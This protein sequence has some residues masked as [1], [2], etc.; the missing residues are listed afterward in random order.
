MK[1]WLIALALAFVVALTA[2]AVGCGGGGE[3]G[4][5]VPTD[6]PTLETTLR[7]IAP[8]LDDLPSGFAIQEPGEVY[9][10]N[11]EA[12]ATDPD[13]KQVALDRYNEWGRLLGYR[14]SYM[15]NDTMGAFINGG[16]ATVTV[17]L[18]IFRTSEGAIAAMEWGR[19]VA[20]D[21]SRNMAL[22]PGVISMEAEPMS[23]T[24]IGDETLAARFT[25]K[26]RPQNMAA[27]V[28]VDFI[29][30]MVAIRRGRATAYII[31]SAISGAEPGPEVEALIRVLDANLV[32]ALE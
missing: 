15:T 11:E 12:A 9:T 18:S 17:V 19:E 2:V 1:T 14:A 7:S 10:D 22:T 28:D 25:G 24:S 21:T 20:T 26:I 6:R 13:G 8:T 16:T 30:H 5:D 29:S 27:Q 23:F 31:V 3:E 4:S 32:K